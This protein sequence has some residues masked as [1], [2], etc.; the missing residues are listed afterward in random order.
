MAGQA[1]PV[2]EHSVRGRFNCAYAHFITS[3]VVKVEVQ[4]S[5]GVKEWKLSPKSY[6]LEAKADGNF[7]RFDLPSAKYLVLRFWLDRLIPTKKRTVFPVL[8][9]RNQVHSQGVAFDV[10]AKRVEM[11]IVLNRKAL[12]T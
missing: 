5:S 9:R 1:V 3:G 10:S 6:Q 12:E 2:V 4:V 11:F 8:G 7:I